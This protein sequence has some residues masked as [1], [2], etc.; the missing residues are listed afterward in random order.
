MSFTQC[1]AQFTTT[2]DTFLRPGGG[3]GPGVRMVNPA[4]SGEMNIGVGTIT[5]PIPAASSGT[6]SLEINIVAGGAL[7]INGSGGAVG[8]H[9]ENI[10]GPYVVTD[11]TFTFTPTGEPATTWTM[12]S[13]NIV[14]G[15]A[16]TLYLVRKEN[17]QCINGL[18]AT[19]Q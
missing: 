10:S 12:R 14:S 18:T 11:T 2:P 5:F 19:K 8:I 9:T 1:Q 3:S 4:K 6:A 16:R 15:V 17:A 7:K 13:G